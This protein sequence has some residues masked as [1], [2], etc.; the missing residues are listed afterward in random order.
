MVGLI[1]A[2]LLVAMVW[3]LFYGMTAT[4]GPEVRRR[5]EWMGL[6]DLDERPV[7]TPKSKPEIKRAA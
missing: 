1:I 6:G 4:T 7:T 2:G 3:L 5:F